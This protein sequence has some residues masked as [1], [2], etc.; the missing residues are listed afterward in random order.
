MACCGVVKRRRNRII[1]KGNGF[2]L[3]EISSVKRLFFALWPDPETRAQ[4]A[5]IAA[6][7]KQPGHPVHPDNLHVTLV[8]LGGIDEASEMKLVEAAASI[9]FSRITINFKALR[10]WHKPRILC[11]IG[12]PEDSAAINLVNQLSTLAASLN[13]PVDE[14]SYQAHV[15]LLRKTTQSP[16]LTFEP[17]IW[18]A[19]AFCLVESCA[20]PEGVVYRVLKTW[21]APQIPDNADAETHAGL[22]N[23]SGAIIIDATS[24][25]HRP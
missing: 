25:A 3:P 24:S 2:V 12:E 5:A 1:A 6:T 7:L 14:R 20:E 18:R 10:Y 17:I 22:T 9:N 8:F 15:T 23:A 11:L 19:D 13:I 4:C 21:Q 16:S